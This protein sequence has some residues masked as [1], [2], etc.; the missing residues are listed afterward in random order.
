M[1]IDATDRKLLSIIL[2]AATTSKAEL[3]RRVGLAAS[4]VSERMRRL[5]ETG[6]VEG[7]EARLN[8]RALAMPL[9]AFVFVREL[10]PNRGIDTAEALS[11][12]TGVE[13]VHKIAGEDC[14]LVKLRARGTE[15]LGA[16]L[17]TE[18]DAI[19]TVIGVRTSIVLKS[20]LEGP[21]L[22]G[23]SIF[24]EPTGESDAIEVDPTPT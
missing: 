11:Q 9:L 16:T 7:Y 1:Q 15:E 4:A 2:R 6:I 22:S 24:A 5:E 12:V 10:K 21:P 20:I 14:F 13:E 18:I 8:A 3:A 19:P 17:D 23:A